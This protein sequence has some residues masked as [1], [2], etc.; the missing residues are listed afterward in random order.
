M[1]RRLK[2]WFNDIRYGPM[3]KAM[4]DGGTEI[5]S[6]S[7]CRDC[8]C[9]ACTLAWEVTRLPMA[10]GRDLYRVQ[11]GPIYSHKGHDALYVYLRGGDMIDLTLY[12]TSGAFL[13]IHS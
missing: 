13:L 11:F 9:K 3:C 4:L 10:A 8:G 12:A 1:P 7:A 6:I 2:R 5:A